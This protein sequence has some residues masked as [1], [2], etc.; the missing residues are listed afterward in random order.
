[1]V[2]GL[3]LA[4]LT[5]CSI[6]IDHPYRGRPYYARSYRDHGWGRAD[7]DRGRRHVRDWNGY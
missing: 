1:M 5:G 4:T 2:L 6:R 3:T 7:F